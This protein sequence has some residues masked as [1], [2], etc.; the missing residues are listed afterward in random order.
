M[1]T[2]EERN[3]EL[4]L[5]FLG[6]KDERTTSIWQEMLADDDYTGKGL[7]GLE[8]DEAIEKWI[9]LKRNG[10]SKRIVKASAPA[11]AGVD[12]DPYF[13]IFGDNK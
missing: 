13:N 8:Q 4:T 5:L 12:D 3:R 7:I 10:K 9:E 11:P 6:V 1:K 2:K